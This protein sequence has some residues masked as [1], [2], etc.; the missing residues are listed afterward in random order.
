M[1]IFEQAE[2]L[3]KKEFE[4]IDLICDEFLK[5]KPPAVRDSIKG[6]LK[7]FD[8]VLSRRLRFSSEHFD[9][10]L[11]ESVEKTEFLEVIRVR[12]VNPR[13]TGNHGFG[14][15]FRLHPSVSI[16]LMKID[17][18][19]MT[20]KHALIGPTDY[21]RIP[22]GG[23]KGG[24][25]VDP[26]QYKKSDLIRLIRRA[27]Q[28]LNPM[29]GPRRDRF[30]PDMGVD[31]K[32]MDEFMVHYS[33]LNQGKDIPCGAIVSGKSL[34]EG[35]CPGRRS[36]TA[37]GMYDV[38]E[39]IKNTDKYKKYFSRG[40]RTIIIGFGNVGSEFVRLA[41]R[42]HL[43][44]V[45]IADE[46]GAVY[47]KDGGLEEDFPALMTASKNSE[48]IKSYPGAESLT[49]NELLRQPHDILAPAAVEGMINVDIAKILDSRI[50][51][52]GANGPTLP[53]A[54]LIFAD[55]DVLV[56]PDILANAGG[57]TVSYF[58][59]LQAIQG[60]Y[61]DEE[62]V[63]KRRQKYMFGGAARTLKTADFFDVSIR[64][65]ALISSVD[66]LSRRLSR[67]RHYNL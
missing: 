1:L 27:V 23:A 11:K 15:G 37:E 54:D 4:R 10:L 29:I 9:E 26:R 42:N 18:L 22:F 41:A 8:T 63:A 43:S 46:N 56:I 57:A 59:W 64:Q 67:K 24:I 48:G 36:A 19:K 61:F 6:E 50:I 28:K 62:L 14:G 32:L 34:E 49:F 17:A 33:D 31:E 47:K 40:L 66:Y 38:L 2:E 3:L 65:A 16:P 55:K 21:A 35:G 39:V 30:G 7:S 12:H 5:I 60:E 51:L 44:I 52:E 45:G 53:S 20:L 58:E 25:A 13:A